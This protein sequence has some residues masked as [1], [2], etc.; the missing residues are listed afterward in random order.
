MKYRTNI[1]E[2]FKRRW[3]E[4]RCDGCLQ[5]ALDVGAKERGFIP[6]IQLD[7]E[8]E[9]G[10]SR[11][12]VIT[13]MDSGNVFARIRCATEKERVEWITA[14]ELAK[15]PSRLK[16]WA[17]QPRTSP[18]TDTSSPTTENRHDECTESSYV[19]T[20]LLWRLN[21]PSAEFILLSEW[22]DLKDSLNLF[23]MLRSDVGRDDDCSSSDD[24]DDDSVQSPQEVLELNDIV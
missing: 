3:F 16:S 19:A 15:E 24:V 2:G 20:L 9:K 10:S 23:F 13:H 4:L 7:V 21:W 6:V 12:F 18:D 14:L 5:Y 11:N 1:I 17:T 22:Q 8:V